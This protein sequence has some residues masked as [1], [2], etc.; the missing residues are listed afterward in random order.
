MQLGHPIVRH[1]QLQLADPQHVAHLG[2]L[3]LRLVHPGR[4][5]RQHLLAGGIQGGLLA[6]ALLR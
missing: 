3:V 6:Q 2:A 4:R 5:V 1:L